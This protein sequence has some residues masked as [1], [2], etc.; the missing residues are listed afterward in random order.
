MDLV[1]WLNVNR[2]LSFVICFSF[3]HGKLSSA[4]CL[5]FMQVLLSC[6]LL[7]IAKCVGFSH[8]YLV[9]LVGVG[10]FSFLYAQRVV[11]CYTPGRPSVCVSVHLCVCPSVCLSVRWQNLVNATPPTAFG[12]F[13]SNL[14]KHIIMV[15]SC[16]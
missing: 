10:L 13:L 1:I 2:R 4:C 6:L 7:C 11:L 3:L 15:C 12:G 5:M 8:L 14:L 9:S 16:A